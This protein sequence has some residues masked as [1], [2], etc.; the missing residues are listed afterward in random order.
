MIRLTIS[1]VSGVLEGA[2]RLTN[3]CLFGIIQDYP[4]ILAADV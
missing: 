4:L 3:L 1:F 2:Q